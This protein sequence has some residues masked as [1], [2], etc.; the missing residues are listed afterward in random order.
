MK[1][2]TTDGDERL[3]EALTIDEACQVDDIGVTEQVSFYDR[4][5]V[6]AVPEVSYALE[7][8]R[9]DMRRD[10]IVGHEPAGHHHN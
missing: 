3:G 10:D 6:L 1:L 9:S 2:K 4:L 7:D 8:R 5:V